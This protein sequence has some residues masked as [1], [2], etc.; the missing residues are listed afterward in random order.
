M[1]L[2]I[3]RPRLSFTTL[4]YST[5]PYRR[6]LKKGLEI[7][8]R[9]TITKLFSNRGIG[10]VATDGGDEVRFHFAKLDG[11]RSEDLRIGQRVECEVVEKD[12]GILRA[13]SVRP[14]R[15]DS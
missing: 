11:M 14:V 2:C 3:L 7:M 12:Y 5:R 15:T 8:S 1:N 6:F 9:G 4:N 10:C 13:T